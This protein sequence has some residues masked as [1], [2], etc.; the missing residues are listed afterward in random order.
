MGTS[1]AIPSH[2][3]IRGRSRSPRRVGIVNV[4]AAV[5]RRRRISAAQVH[6]C[7]LIGDDD[8]DAASEGDLLSSSSNRT[9]Y[10]AVRMFNRDLSIS[11]R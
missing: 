6:L 5:G 1:Q 2:L 10:V 11:A 8:D 9:T 4:S 3:Y 7:E